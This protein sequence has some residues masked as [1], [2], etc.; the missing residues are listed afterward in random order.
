MK[1][2]MVLQW[3]CISV[4][5]LCRGILLTGLL[6]GWGQ[7]RSHCEMTSI[8]PSNRSSLQSEPYLLPLP[9]FSESGDTQMAAQVDPSPPTP[10]CVPFNCYVHRIPIS[11]SVV[12]PKDWSSFTLGRKE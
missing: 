12:L 4:E 5:K 1:P 11:L 6:C 2:S 9:G 8:M 7:D 10:T 3:L